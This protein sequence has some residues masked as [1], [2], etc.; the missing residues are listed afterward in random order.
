VGEKPAGEKRAGQRKG[1][2]TGQLVKGNQ[3]QR[4]LAEKRVISARHTK[5]K[6]HKIKKESNVRKPVKSKARE[7]GSLKQEK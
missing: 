3:R 1:E 7:A 6:P 2:I 4:S 5:P